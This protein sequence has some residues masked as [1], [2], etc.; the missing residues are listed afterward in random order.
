VGKSLSN[1]RGRRVLVVED[2]Y[3]IADDLARTIEDAGAEVVGPASTSEAAFALLDG[4]P[5]DL[6]VLDI[7]LAGAVNFTLADELARRNVPFVFAT[8]Y[9]AEMIPAR[10]ANRIRWQKPFQVDEL[11][12]ALGG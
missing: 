7:S 5:I 12:R 11:V 10:H 1:L 4:P 3:F 9:D 8:G 6:A 2:E